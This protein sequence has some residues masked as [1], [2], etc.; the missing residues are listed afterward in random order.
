MKPTGP[1]ALR[2]RRRKPT[3]RPLR[4]DQEATL[5][6]AIRARHPDDLGVTDTLW[7]R[8]AVA[9]YSA[10]RFGVRRSQWVWGQRLRRHGFAAWKESGQSVRA[11]CTACGVSQATL[12]AR[13]RQ[14]T[15]R[16]AR[17]AA[18]PP[19]APTSAAVRVVPDPT[20]EVFLPA[21]LTTL[22]MGDSRF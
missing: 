11:F 1:D 2:P 7:A 5:L 22:G 9:E 13:R 20:I 17:A 14:L 3:G 4:P 16:S 15:D 18:I 10:D 12:F 19:A 21:G 8:D 6:D